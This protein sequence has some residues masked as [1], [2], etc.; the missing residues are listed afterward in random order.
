VTIF[1]HITSK[2]KKKAKT[3]KKNEKRA[4]ESPEKK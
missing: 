2:T 1:H 4:A 3:K